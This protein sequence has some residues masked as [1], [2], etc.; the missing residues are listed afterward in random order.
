MQ[1]SGAAHPDA[2]KI[3]IFHM[4]LCIMLFIVGMYE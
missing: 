2:D 4:M 1:G 3:V